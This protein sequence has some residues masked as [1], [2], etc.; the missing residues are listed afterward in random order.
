LQKET[1]TV[2]KVNWGS[3]IF[4]SKMIDIFIFSFDVDH[5][6]YQICDKWKHCMANTGI[7]CER[8]H[9][10]ST[11]IRESYICTLRD[12]VHDIFCNSRHLEKVTGCEDDAASNGGTNC[13]GLNIGSNQCNSPTVINLRHFL[14]ENHLDKLYNKNIN[15]ADCK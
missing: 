7:S 14:L 13:N 6:Q 2:Q 4:E 11:Q 8:Y 15:L 5:V 3:T 12:E 10:T 9:A 1:F